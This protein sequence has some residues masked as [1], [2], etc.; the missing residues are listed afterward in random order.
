MNDLKFSLFKC[1][2]SYQ[3]KPVGVEEIVRLIKYDTIVRQRTEQYRQ[4][5]HVVSREKA[6]EEVKQKLLPA[7][8]VGV[9]F[10][11]AGRKAAQIV[12]ATGFCLCDIDHMDLS[13]MED[14]IS[15]IR[16]DPHT[17]LCYR[18]VSGEGVRVIYQFVRTS[19]HINCEAYPAAWKKGNEYFQRLTGCEYDRACSDFGR[20]SGLAHDEEVYLNPD[21]EPFVITDEEMAA[22]SIASHKE[23][24][25]PRK[26]FQPGSNHSTVEEAWPVVQRSLSLRGIA[27]TTGH[28]HDFMVLAAYLFNRFGTPRDQLVEW[29][30]QEWGDMPKEEREDVIGHCYRKTEEHGIWKLQQPSKAGRR[31]ALLSTTEIRA[32][33]TERCTVVYNVVNDQT[34]Y[35]RKLAA[36]ADG[37]HDPAEEE[38][39]VIDERVEE[40]MRCQMEADTGKRVLTKDVASVLRSDFSLLIHPIRDYL[41]AL[42]SWDGV[43]RVAE[44]AAHLTAEPTL[45]SQSQEEAQVDIAWALHKWLVGMVATWDSCQQTN[46]TVF[47]LIGEQGCYKTTFFRYLLPPALRSYFLENRH[48]SFASKDDKLS[49]AENCL[50]EIEEVEAISGKELSE[51]KTLVTADYIKERRPYARYRTRKERLASFCASGNQ[52]QFLTDQTGN[53][54]WLCF[55]VSRIDN[56]RD[57]QLDYDQLYA[58]LRSE[59]LKGFQ[60][61][62]DKQEEQRVERLNQPF[63]IISLEEQ[64]ICSRL[65]KPRGRETPKQ[66]SSSM[67]A[68]LLTGGHLTTAISVRKIGD[69]MRQLNFKWKHHRDGDYYYVIEIPLN[70]VQ[71]YL[72]EVQK[73]D[74]DDSQTA[75]TE[76]LVLP[77]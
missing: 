75:D 68:M 6:N 70:D 53:R 48:N 61:W 23:P 56:P 18:S 63:R 5:A 24:G 13:K 9:L 11:N 42:P 66:M 46:H 17:W 62:F 31:N 15:K 10:N 77:F 74:E 16:Q 14:S 36:P 71:N 37:A 27:Y 57:W 52:Q 47:V 4:M 65:R 20:L 26:E 8:S 38:W 1:L 59:Y 35:R 76:E 39:Q 19:S 2:D 60:F 44:L 30:S 41:E 67:I 72:N 40:S 7:F 29:A 43:D 49:I 45:G 32:W 69:V 54:R 21:A 3:S 50:V 58:Q 55:R 22:E 12:R 34:M 25:R 28:R 64:L 33:L 51:L 73:P